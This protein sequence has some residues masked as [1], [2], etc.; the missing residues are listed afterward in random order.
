MWISDCN[1]TCTNLKNF[2]EITNIAEDGSNGNIVYGKRWFFNDKGELCN[3][4]IKVLAVCESSKSA[5][6]YLRELAEKL[7]AEKNIVTF[8]DILTKSE[9]Q[10]ENAAV[11]SAPVVVALHSTS[12]AEGHC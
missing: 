5:M 12:T 10:S 11:L 7:N 3:K 6:N 2:D 9:N 1:Y 8:G 4:F